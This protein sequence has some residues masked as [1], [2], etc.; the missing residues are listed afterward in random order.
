MHWRQ[1]PCRDFKLHDPMGG[2]ASTYLAAEAAKA[3]AVE[4]LPA[5]PSTPNLS[6]AQTG[7]RNL[8]KIRTAASGGDSTSVSGATVL[9]QRGWLRPSVRQ[10]GATPKGP[11]S[12]MSF[13]V[14]AGVLL[15]QGSKRRV[16]PDPSAEGQPAVRPHRSSAL[17]P[18]RVFALRKSSSSNSAARPRKQLKG[19]CGPGAAAP[20]ARALQGCGA[21]TITGRQ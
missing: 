1:A 18:L 15:G 9:P 4:A 19:G 12:A 2:E 21:W 11:N 6:R 14:R 3:V 5:R 10:K 17:S 8:R 20:Q 16:I 7:P 13:E